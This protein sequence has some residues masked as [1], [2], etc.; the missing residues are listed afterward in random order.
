MQTVE[1]TI[2]VRNSRKR[3]RTRAVVIPGLVSVVLL[4]GLSLLMFWPAHPSVNDTQHITV[5]STRAQ[6][7]AILGP[8]YFDSPMLALW[9]LSD[10]YVDVNFGEDGLV[11]QSPQVTHADAFKRVSIRLA[12]LFENRFFWWLDAKFY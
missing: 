6:A 10:G 1:N 2:P 12:A 4:V 9:V 7:M 5:G 3:N 11:T 8:P